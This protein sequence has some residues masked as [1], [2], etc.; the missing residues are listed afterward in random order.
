[1][2]SVFCS[3]QQHQ[4]VAFYICYIMLRYICYVCLQKFFLQRCAMSHVVVR[5]SQTIFYGTNEH[6]AK[7][8]PIFVC[9]LSVRQKLQILKT[10]PKMKMCQK[11]V[12]LPKINITP[13]LIGSVLLGFFFLPA[14]H[15]QHTLRTTFCFI[16]VTPPCS[17]L[18]HLQNQRSVVG[19]FIQETFRIKENNH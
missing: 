15:C 11:R 9:H 6:L 5:C 14:S 2:V 16:L 13:K 12:M 17:W 8:Y 7:F 10:T 4:H 18:G 19:I 1:M 3:A